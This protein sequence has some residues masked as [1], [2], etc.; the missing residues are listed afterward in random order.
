MTAVDGR[1][2]RSRPRP[3][4]FRRQIVILTGA[5]TTFAVVVLVILVQLVLAQVATNTVARVLLERTDAIISSADASS[6]STQL[7]VPA[8]SLDAGVAVF[9]PAG[10]LVAG[11][12]PSSLADEYAELGRSTAQRTITVDDD[13]IRAQPF[14]TAAGAG[15]V[16]VVT[17]KLAPYEN[18]ERYAFVVSAVAGLLMI[19]ATMTLAAWVSRRALRPVADMAAT[20]EDWSEHDLSRRFDLGEPRNEITALGRTLD[21]LLDKVSSVIRSEQRLTSELAHE[22]RTP[23]T[24]VQGCA[25]LVLMRGDL[26]PEVRAEVEEMRSGTGRMADTITSL[27]ELA[28]SESSMQGSASCLLSEVLTDVA[29]QGDGGA[30]LVVDS[31]SSIR[32]AVPHTLAVRALSPIVQNAV[33][34]ADHVHVSARVEASGLVAILVDDD[35]PGVELSQRAAIFVPGHTSG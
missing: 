10:T 34:L 4:S 9:D 35:G 32:L 5:V 26:P 15:G 7:V 18:A 19:V 30:E 3:G 22:L 29:A 25:D 13:R 28:R 23:L 1:S 11:A 14:T 20:A 2:W 8:A 21:G 6:T 31:G 24:A 17:E 33:R 12:A 16:V 27:L